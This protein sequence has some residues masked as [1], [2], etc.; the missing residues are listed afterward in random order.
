MER[1]SSKLQS[2]NDVWK[3]A[4]N[5]VAQV[6]RESLC[7]EIEPMNHARTLFLGESLY[8]GIHGVILLRMAF[9]RLMLTM[10]DASPAVNPT[11]HAPTLP[12]IHHIYQTHQ[13]KRTRWPRLNVQVYIR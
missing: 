3:T 6:C 7:S 8:V 4:R 13:K 9:R 10:V 12:G 11:S 2:V 5:V 1:Q